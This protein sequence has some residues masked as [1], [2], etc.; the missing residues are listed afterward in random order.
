MTTNGV[1]RM[2]VNTSGNVGIGQASPNYTLD[3]NGNA[4]LTSYLDVANLIA[5]SS[6]ATSTFAGGMIGPEN[7]TIQQATGNV[8]INTN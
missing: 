1:E 2:R 7:F 8:G 4:R 3:I 6:T 5:T